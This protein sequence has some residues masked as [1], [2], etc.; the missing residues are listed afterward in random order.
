M[1]GNEN[2][3]NND[4]ARIKKNK[5][6]RINNINEIKFKVGDEPERNEQ[7][8]AQTMKAIGV[9]KL[10]FSFVFSLQQKPNKYIE[11]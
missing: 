1:K 9:K 6:K 8:G 10:F 4:L 11:K 2:N 5:N 3:N 7:N